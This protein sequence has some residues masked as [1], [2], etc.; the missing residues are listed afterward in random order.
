M[1]GPI[2][3]GAESARMDI[4]GMLLR[5]STRMRHRE[6]VMRGSGFASNV[7]HVRQRLARLVRK[8]EGT[9]RRSETN[10]DCWAIGV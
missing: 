4:R 2:V 3:G 8:R 5:A 9:G 10:R 7:R 6:D 1:L